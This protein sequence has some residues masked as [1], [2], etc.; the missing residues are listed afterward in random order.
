MDM[1]MPE[2][3]GYQATKRI[4]ANP[5]LQHIP[6]IAVTAS[7][8]REEEARARKICDGFIRKP[9]NLSELVAELAKFLRPSEVIPQ[10][11]TPI[12]SAASQ[13]DHAS[14]EG[15]ARR[16]ALLAQLREEQKS[17]W[18]ELCRTLSMDEAEAFANRLK[19]AA[20]SGEWEL[21]RDYANDLVTQIQQFDLSK[22]PA[23]LRRF[24]EIC[25]TLAQS[26]GAS[27]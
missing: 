12:E 11:T 23:F 25:D 24:P 1:R 10:S 19:T 27:R 3:D 18:P 26:E 13:Q 16:P 7:S 22:L 4:K 8:F 2:L 17:V 9:F 20:D 15:I 5:D 14:P 6:I 21:L